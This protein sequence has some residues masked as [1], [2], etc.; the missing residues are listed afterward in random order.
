MPPTGRSIWAMPVQRPY[1]PNARRTAEMM[2]SDLAKVGIKAEIVSYDWTEYLKRSLE[3]DRD[4]AV[5]LGWTG[6][7]ADRSEDNSLNLL[8]L[9]PNIALL[10]V[11]GII[12][13]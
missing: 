12:H 10:A 6:G 4:G 8:I 5:I 7:I 1:M 2:Q 13:W 11:G 9:S 3:K